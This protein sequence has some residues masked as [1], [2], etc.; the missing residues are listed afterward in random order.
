M[1]RVSFF[2]TSLILK[3]RIPSS[4]FPFDQAQTHSL[5]YWS[6]QHL[7]PKT[8]YLLL[9]S[10]SNFC[11]FRLHAACCKCLPGFQVA[12][13]RMTSVLEC[14]CSEE[15]SQWVCLSF[16]VSQGQKSINR[17]SQCLTQPPMTPLQSR[18]HCQNAWYSFFQ[19]F[20]L[21]SYFFI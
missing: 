15:Q 21:W 12:A 17:Q 7:T 8:V 2:N 9:L 19:Q 1:V 20:H 18:S 5:A 6:W 11:A 3:S 16:H 10:I 4:S 13:S 14:C